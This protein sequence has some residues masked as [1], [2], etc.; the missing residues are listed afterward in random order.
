MRDAA[1]SWQT[2]LCAAALVC[3]CVPCLGLCV[4][5][6]TFD[7][8]GDGH[9]L[10]QEM[11][12]LLNPAGYMLLD[13]EGQPDIARILRREMLPAQWDKATA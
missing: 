1:W 13:L 6:C 2:W 4:F 8:L 11:A 10:V 7:V 3:C 9:G 12:S 5:R